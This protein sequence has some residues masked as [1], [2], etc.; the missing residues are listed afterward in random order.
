M[1]NVVFGDVLLQWDYTLISINLGEKFQKEFL[2]I[3]GE[4]TIFFFC[5]PK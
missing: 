4:F 5:F 1:K 3:S 2:K